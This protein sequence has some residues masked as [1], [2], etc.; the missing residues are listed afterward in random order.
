MNWTVGRKIAAGFGLSLVIFVAVGVISHRATVQLVEA[1]DLRKTS[2]ETL[3]ALSDV[4]LALRGV[5]VTLRTYLLSGE[6]AHWQAL[7]SAEKSLEPPV[8]RLREL[9]A[10]TPAQAKRVDKVAELLGGYE[11]ATNAIADLRRTKGAVPATQAFLADSTRQMQGDIAGLLAELQQEHQAALARRTQ[12][13]ENDAAFA[14]AAILYGNTLAV[15][16]ALLAGYLITRNISGPLRSLTLTAERVTA[17][18]LGVEEPDSTR[19]D[20]I[21]VLARALDR[22]RRSLR[23]MAETAEQIATGDLRASV[24]PQSRADVLGNAFARMTTDLR[25]QIKELIEGANVLS[26]AASEIVA[27]SSQL[28]ASATQSA[29]AVSETTTTV[30]EVRQTAQ[31]ASQKARLVSDSAQKAAQ[32]GEGG[33]KS[34]Q[35]VEAGMARIRRQMEQIAAS[36]VQL[37]EQSQAV[38]QIIA[39]VEDIATQS[40]LLAV[41]AAIEAAKAGEH[42]RGF[43]VVAQE[44]KTLAEQSRQATAQVRSILGDIQKATAAAVLATEEGGKVVDSGA[45]QADVAGTTIQ[46]LAASVNEAAQ[47]AVQIAASSQQQLVGVDQVAGAMES[48]KEAS[49][50][51]VVSA[52]QLEATARGLQE[53]GQRLQQMVGRYKA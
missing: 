35:D 1:S 38:A 32:I 11:V 25:A 37:S 12:D 24:T 51:N 47:A 7:R 34:A 31:L 3:D 14:Q 42:G 15:A 26:A 27:S 48:I 43:G 9:V 45:Q 52:T 29:A 53:L 2:Y 44:V 49:A 16:I 6:E 4:R 20:E 17:G 5:G 8:R 19:G 22:M 23:G 46:A 30:E 28:A 13:T 10:S 21:G 41:N 39:T 33:R 40:N 18:D 36:M 50:Q